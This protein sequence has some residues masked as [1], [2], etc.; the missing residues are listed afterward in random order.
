ML[1]RSEMARLSSHQFNALDLTR[2]QKKIGKQLMV[3]L[4]MREM[5]RAR[6]RQWAGMESEKSLGNV[7]YLKG[8]FH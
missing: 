5:L 4:E 1:Y 6:L 3:Y 7:A 8:A 2:E